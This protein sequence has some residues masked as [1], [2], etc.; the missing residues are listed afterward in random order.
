[1]WYYLEIR[2]GN[3]SPNIY[4]G[5]VNPAQS[6]THCCKDKATQRLAWAACFYFPWSYISKRLC[7]NRKI[8]KAL[9]EEFG[10]GNAG[11]EHLYRRRMCWS[12]FGLSKKHS[13]GQLCDVQSEMAF[14]WRFHVLDIYA[15]ISLP[16]R[17]FSRSSAEEFYFVIFTTFLQE[18]GLRYLVFVYFRNMTT[19]KY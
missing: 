7:F 4:L 13:Y 3:N 5:L 6:C 8:E 10:S 18:H 19:W 9:K 11:S 2:L 16:L 14:R 15:T 17:A 12:L 1:M